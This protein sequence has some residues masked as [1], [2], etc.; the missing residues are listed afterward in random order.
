MKNIYLF[1]IFKSYYCL[2]VFVLMA[3]ISYFLV[4]EKIFY[5]FYNLMALVFI[6][7]FSLTLTCMVR[8]IKDR[9]VE[10]RKQ[11][12]KPIWGVLIGLIGLSALQT[13]AIG[14]PI[15]GASIGMAIV[16]AIF[17]TLAF[18]FINDYSLE[19]I[20]FSVFIQI[21]SLYQMKCFKKV[22]CD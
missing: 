7:V 21:I 16:S 5:G 19:V 9:I 3:L 4:P 18:D 13:C 2:A 1:K 8:S 12:V 15:C 17:P 20:I 22:K 11:A 6:L 10:H 14:A